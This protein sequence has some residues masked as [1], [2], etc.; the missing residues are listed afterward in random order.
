M[1]LAASRPSTTARRSASP[2]HSPTNPYANLDPNIHPIAATLNSVSAPSASVD[3]SGSHTHR[4]LSPHESNR[5]TDFAQH[6]LG[7]SGAQGDA[8]N[9]LAFTEGAGDELFQAGD[10]SHFEGLLQ[11]AAAE[12]TANNASAEGAVGGDGYTVTG[13]VIQ[14]DEAT[15]LQQEGGNSHQDRPGRKRKRDGEEATL[16]ENGEH[17]DPIRLKKDSHKEVERR[18]REN[19]NDGIMEI[20]RHVP[21]GSDKMGKGTL[22]RRAA[23]YLS[24]VTIKV[25]NVDREI[26]K[27]D[28]EKQEIQNELTLT[29]QRLAEEHARS[30]RYETSWR[31]A[32]DRAAVS[33]FELERVR[34]ELEELKGR[35]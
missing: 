2:T 23:E 15:G 34:A 4:S 35:Q 28:S 16:D 9:L 10:G 24:E 33:Q 17:M 29:Q 25:E 11:E 19:I 32:E 21:G 7:E 5:L 6:V 27:R 20:A 1:S 3:Q 31:E 13:D 18:R 26:A 22:L 14:V 30:I 8:E 12:E